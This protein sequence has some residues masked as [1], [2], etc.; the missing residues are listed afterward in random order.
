M[1]GLKL[2]LLFLLLSGALSGTL[3]AQDVVRDV[4]QEGNIET[5]VIKRPKR[6]D[7]HEFRFGAGTYSVA[8]DMF[9]DGIGCCDEELNFRD[10]MAVADTYLSKRRFWGTYSLGYTYHSLRWFQFGATVS[11]SAA[12]Q[13]RH[14]NLTGNKVEN[15]NQYAVGIMPTFRFIYLYR[16]DIQLYSAISLGAVLGTNMGGFWADT[17]LFGCSVGRNLFGFAEI[18][19]GLGGWG[20]IGIGYRF[21]SSKKG[22][23]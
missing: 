13:A 3:S 2:L 20:R 5:V 21:D 18:G 6:V 15:L 17:T 19:A 14:D 7:K 12:T 9:L 11:F 16:D 4:Q 1:K 8:A 23:K 10:D 22:K